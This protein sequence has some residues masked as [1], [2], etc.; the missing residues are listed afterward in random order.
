MLYITS[1]KNNN[2]SYQEIPSPRPMLEPSKMPKSSGSSSASR[3]STSSPEIACSPRKKAPTKTP[4]KEFYTTSA[5]ALSGWN[6]FPILI[7][8]VCRKK[9]Y[10]K[11][12]SGKRNRP[13][14]VLYLCARLNVVVDF[15]LGRHHTFISFYNGRSNCGWQYF[16]LFRLDISWC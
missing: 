1:Q 9:K 2:K 8:I 5:R 14:N 15:T 10:G 16:L 4:R 7:I 11:E 3:R 6:M 13:Y 12:T